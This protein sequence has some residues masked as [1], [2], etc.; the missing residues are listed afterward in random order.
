VVDSSVPGCGANV[1]N[2]SGFPQIRVIDEDIGN[3]ERFASE[4]RASQVIF[5]LAGEISHIHSMRHPERD[6][7]LNATAQLRFLEACARHAPG[8]RIVYAS[9]RQIYGVPRYLPVDENHP[10]QP[11]DFNGVHKYAATQYHLMYSAMG[12]LDAAVLCLTNVYGPRMAL[13]IPC[14]GFL[15][16]FIRRSLLGQPIEIFGDGSQLRDPVY[17]DD[18]VEAFLIT[19]AAKSL[20]TRIYNLGGPEPLPLACIAGSISR[21]AGAPSPQ[22]RA[23]PEE[24]K[25]IDIGSYYSSSERLRGSYGWHASVMFEEGVGRTLDYFRE[26]LAHY[27][28]PADIKPSCALEKREIEIRA[29]AAS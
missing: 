18:V 25:R 8:V 22:F 2:L 4:I 21:A 17:V 16:N 26:G 19:G 27:L 10:V 13:N 12:K 20:E 3:P 9:T 5:N 29:L 7:E 6:A 14:Q 15:S 1:H 11:A 28:S 24:M 23:F